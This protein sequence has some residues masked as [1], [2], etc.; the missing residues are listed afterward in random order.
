MGND[1][2]VSKQMAEEFGWLILDGYIAM[3]AYQYVAIRVSRKWNKRNNNCALVVGA[4]FPKE[5]GLVRRLVDDLTILIPAV[6]KQ[7]GEVT[8]TVQAGRNSKKQG[9]IINNSRAIIFASGGSDF[10]EAARAKTIAMNKQI[11]EAQAA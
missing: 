10:A 3:P 5:L 9:M 4:T 11:D 6:G 2:V 7:G 1:F 8:P